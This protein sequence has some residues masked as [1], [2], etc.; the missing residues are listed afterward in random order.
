MRIRFRANL[1]IGGSE[2]FWEDRL[3]GEPDTIVAFRIGRVILHGTNP[4]QRCVV[5]TRVTATGEVQSEFSQIFR[6]RR[7]D[8]LPDWA[9]VSRFNHYYR[10]AVNTQVP[11]SE[12]GKTLHTGDEIEIV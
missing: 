9:A 5:P 10:L 11:E 4:C 3:Y 6:A 2:P 12:I 8:T 1:E 7:Q